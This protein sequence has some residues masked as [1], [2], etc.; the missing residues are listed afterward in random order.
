MWNANFVGAAGA[1]K[2]PPEFRVTTVNCSESLSHRRAGRTTQ[3][4]WVSIAPESFWSV[5]RNHFRFENSPRDGVRV[6][7]E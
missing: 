3:F 6:R 1:S 2:C 7:S 4:G 5:G